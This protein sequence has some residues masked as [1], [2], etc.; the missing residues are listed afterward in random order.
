LLLGTVVAIAIAAQNTRKITESTNNFLFVLLFIT[1]VLNNKKYLPI[2][3]IKSIEFTNFFT[4]FAL[5]FNK[6]KKTHLTF[7]Y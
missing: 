1:P 2:R 4:N 5:L 7:S 6:N 3:I